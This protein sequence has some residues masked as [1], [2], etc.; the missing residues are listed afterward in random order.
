MA[1]DYADEMDKTTDE[2]IRADLQ[3][4]IRK[5]KEFSYG[6]AT[7]EQLDAEYNSRKSL[8][9]GAL[10]NA[11]LGVE[12]AAGFLTPMTLE[13]SKEYED[14]ARAVE[15]L[16]RAEKDSSDLDILGAYRN[17]KYVTDKVASELAA[18]SEEVLRS[19]EVLENSDKYTSTDVD[20]AI[21]TLDNK[22]YSLE[23]RNRLREYYKRAADYERA[24]RNTDKVYDWTSKSWVTKT[25]GSAGSVAANLV[26]GVTAVDEYISAMRYAD[27]NAPLNIYS[28]GFAPTRASLAARQA[29]MDSEKMGEFADWVY[30][31]GMSG[32]DSAL[33]MLISRGLGITSAGAAVLGA[34]AAASTAI[35]MTERGASAAEAFAASAAAGAFETIFEKISIGQFEKLAPKMINLGDSSAFKS[36]FK[37]AVGNLGKSMMVNFSEEALTEIAN[38][39]YDM[40]INGGLSNYEAMIR[41]Y[42]DQG[43]SEEEARAKTAEEFGIQVLQAAAAGALMGA[44]FGGVATGLNIANTTAYNK[45]SDMGRQGKSFAEAQEAIKS[46]LDVETARIAWATGRAEAENAK[47][48]APDAFAN[49]GTEISAANKENTT[50]KAVESQK[51]EKAPVYGGGTASD[52]QSNI[53]NVGKIR[54][55][56]GEAGVKAYDSQFDKAAESPF[57]FESI[58]REAKAGVSFEAAK[59]AAYGTISDKAAKAAYDAGLRDRIL[60]SG[61]ETLAGQE[62]SEYTDIETEGEGHD[63]EKVHL[64]DSGEWAGSENTRRKISAMEEGPGRDQGWQEVQRPADSETASLTYGEKISPSS[65]GIEGGSKSKN[66]QLVTGGETTFTKMATQRAKERGLSAVYFYGNN[67]EIEADG[68]LISARAYI[69]GDRVFIRVDHPV[70]NSDQLM[71]HEI[72]HDKIARGEINPDDV[73][74]RIEEKLGRG[75]AEQAANLYIDAYAGSGMT[76][77]EIWEEVIC[78]SE[79][80]MNIFAG[81]VEESAAGELLTE[82]K[83]AAAETE[84]AESRGPPT[85]GKASREY[86]YP[87]LTDAEWRLYNYTVSKESS[88]SEK[89]ITENVKWLYAKSKGVEVF[90]IYSISDNVDNPTLLFA[91]GQKQAYIDSLCVDEIMW[92]VKNGT[93]RTAEAYHRWFK[94]QQRAAGRNRT[95][96]NNVKNRRTAVGD[97]G[98][99]GH[100]RGQS[101]GQNENNAKGA[102]DSGKVTDKAS[103]ELETL[104]DL[105][106]Q[107]ESLREQVEYW[108]GQTQRTEQPSLRQEDIDKL[109]RRL[110]KKYDSMLEAKEISSEL[111]AL[112]EYIIRNGDG[113]NEL[114]WVEVKDRAVR[115]ASDIVENASVL[116]D[117]G[118]AADYAAVKKAVKGYKLYFA[119]GGDIAD[120]KDFRQRNLGRM[121]LTNNPK[122]TGVDTAYTELQDQFGKGWFPDEYTHPSDQLLHIAELLDSMEPVYENPYSYDMAVATETVANDIIDELIG[123]GVRQAPPTFADKAEK[124]LI[125]QAINDAKRLERA[126]EALKKVRADRDKKIRNLKE[127]YRTKEAKG[128]ESRQARQ[129]RE[130]IE[131]HAKDLSSK[132]LNGT[133]K[134]H[135]P[136]V[137]REPVAKV[138]EAINLSSNYEL[139][140]GSDAK[141]HRVKPGEDRGAEA[142]KRT[143]AFAALRQAYAEIV[144]SGEGT[145]DLDLLGDAGVIAQVMA[146][147]DVPL[148]DMNTEQLELVWTVVRS[149]EG[150]IRSVN[151]EFLGGRYANIVEVAKTLQIANANKVAPTELKSVFGKLQQLSLLDMMTPETFFHRLG[152]AGDAIFRMMRDAQDRHIEI[153]AETQNFAD[154]VMGR[155]DVRRAEKELHTVKLGGKEVKLSTAQ[156]MELYVLSRRKQ[157]VDHIYTGGVRPD[158][159]DG[160][161]LKKETSSEALKGVTLEEVA[162]IVSL[163]TEE[164]VAIADNLQLYLANEMAEYG[165]EA[166]MKVYNYKKFGDAD[167]W[168]IRSDRNEVRSDLPADTAVTTVAGRGFTKNTVPH[169]NNAVRLGSIFDTFSTHVSEMAT[170]AAWLEATEDLNR[171]RNFAFKDGDGNKTG[172][173]KALIGRAHGTR[174]DAYLSKLLA[175]VANGVKGSH[176][177]TSYMGPIVGN[178]KAA[179]VGANLRVVI[180]QPTA[181]LRALKMIDGKYMTK[182]AAHRAN[183]GWKKALAYAPIAKWKDWGYFDINTGRQMKD[184]LFE[185][186]GPVGKV[187]QAS[188]WM[189]GKADSL[190]WGM[191]WNAVEAEVKANNPKIEDGTE[192]FYK[193]VAKRFTEIVDHTQVVDGI[194]QR[195]QIM[196][197]ADGLT[198]MATSFLGEPTKQ[199]NMMLSAIYDYRNA[200]EGKRTAAKKQLARTAYSLVLSG[201]VNAMAQSI[202]DALRDDDDEKNYWEKWLTAMLGFDGDED[203]VKEKALAFL[204]GNLQSTFNPIASVPFAK[205]VMSIIQ[206]YDVSRMDM[207]AVDK[208]ITAAG[209]FIASLGGDSKYTVSSA[210]LGLASEVGRLLGIPLYNVVRDTKAIAMTAA[211]ATDSYV[212]QYMMEKAAKNIGYGGN[213]SAFIDVLYAAYHNDKEAY[214]LIY[215]DMAKSGMDPAKI[216]SSFESRSTEAFWEQFPKNELPDEAE[217]AMTGEQLA[218]Y[219]E[220][221][222]ATMVGVATALASSEDFVMLTDEQQNKAMNAVLKYSDEIAKAM[223]VDGYEPETEWVNILWANNEDQDMVAQFIIT[224]TVIGDIESTDAAP[225][226]HQVI[227]YLV[228]TDMSDSDLW[229]TYT[230]YYTAE[231]EPAR[232]KVGIKEYLSLAKSYGSAA[233]NSERTLEA[234]EA[235]IPLGIYL[236]YNNARTQFKGDGKKEMC[237]EYI[238]ALNVSDQ[239]KDALFL[240]DYKESGLR[241]TPW[242]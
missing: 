20:A 161:G 35:D 220:S 155:F 147:Q 135:I 121:T 18:V 231:Y 105:R 1:T 78:D 188:M 198:K 57:A 34:S 94:N 206:G 230:A 92:E 47:E 170:Y 31:T 48:T 96:G 190:T 127:H 6:A 193:T 108:K 62:K 133:D 215:D 19:L 209:K 205:D 234:V 28:R 182:G 165:N 236:Q 158:D 145:V 172:T 130:K 157:A 218:V 212:L 152:D 103:R 184:V 30:Q 66:I 2:A 238:D 168:P 95:G 56:L 227:D 216:E 144:A 39:A 26:G 120:Y 208:T 12:K 221:H 41:S 213:N 229:N 148:A 65:L 82:T 93:V 207:Q 10:E 195:S 32:I 164:Q 232:L 15:D 99:S 201:V 176:R 13:G 29:V 97:G 239:V 24:T 109:A 199:Y 21:R 88:I 131:R 129:L 177:E 240:M 79:G 117:D 107:N 14:Y 223:A 33:G 70:Y 75:K 174:G 50:P 84:T 116:V 222:D 143:L 74:Q 69:S 196:R 166:S 45:Y 191:L 126:K 156:I 91:E 71:R 23:E 43:M 219:T 27:E 73:R 104:N 149:I 204:Q 237:V 180:Q 179:S 197:S 183:A 9:E 68:V 114:T 53:V 85:E 58:Y 210:L 138:L 112:G 67:L 214:R 140:F 52:A 228:S 242:N 81:T 225:K 185:T 163:L 202:V 98:I 86:W 178:Y 173:V 125:R 25:L 11:R 187:K 139:S 186:D 167:Y 55:Q 37:T 60:E 124:K 110:V 217:E 40:M 61:K 118:S 136:E 119:N 115:I 59:S 22:G 102:G 192:E 51:R 83:A 189:A 17:R 122:D 89:Y 200:P 63:T 146:M 101:P 113:Q 142:T 100:H 226:Q 141:Y 134:K 42:I 241:D 171:I 7:Y 87:K 76:A 16:H 38:I 80:D 123:E 36:V 181:I 159:V 160:K 132:L 4:K 224:K 150:T 49:G 211:Q 194:L 46:S 153:M 90:A 72:G 235:D 162:E 106:R 137:L 77:E 5:A 151:K 8:V 233:M 154:R 111:K 64:R 3:A 175:D 44:G 203:T 128:R 54:N 169:A